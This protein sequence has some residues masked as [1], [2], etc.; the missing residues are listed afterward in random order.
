MLH[1]VLQMHDYY[2]V[3][4]VFM[5][6]LVRGLLLLSCFVRAPASKKWR[7][8]WAKKFP[9]IM[10]QNNHYFIVSFFGSIFLSHSA[11]IYLYCPLGYGYFFSKQGNPRVFVKGL[12]TIYVRGQ[13]CSLFAYVVHMHKDIIRTFNL[14]YLHYSVFKVLWSKDFFVHMY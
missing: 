14:K 12:R 2:I 11:I 1:G 10:I 13:T 3:L 7:Q 5:L 4:I 8:K 9:Q 6:V